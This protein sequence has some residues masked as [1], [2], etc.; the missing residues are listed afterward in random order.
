MVK[1]QMIGQPTLC[2]FPERNDKRTPFL[3]LARKRVN[4]HQDRR[5]NKGSKVSPGGLL[6]ARVQRHEGKRAGG[7]QS[8]RTRGQ[9]DKRVGGQK[10]ARVRGHKSRRWKGAKVG[11]QKGRRAGGH[12]GLH[13][14]TLSPVCP[15][16]LMPLHPHAFTPS[17]PMSHLVKLG[18][19]EHKGVR[20]QGHEGRWKLGFWVNTSSQVKQVRLQH[21]VSRCLHH[22]H[23]DS[24]PHLH[25]QQKA[26]VGL[27]HGSKIL[28]QKAETSNKGDSKE[29]PIKKTRE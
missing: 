8:R 16:I 13:F 1:L 9:E 28:R 21:V 14:Y 19:E 3:H 27:H 22:L 18:H 24:P 11:G 10:G 15:H 12:K 4:L 6:G 29:P 2:T 5:T 20:A 25:S 17:C 23:I 7:C 26:F